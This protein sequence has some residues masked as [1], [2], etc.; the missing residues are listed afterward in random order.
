MQ[1]RI[2]ADLKQA[3]KA[4]D[5][6]T[7]SVLRMLLSALKYASIE[8]K[9]DLK[10]EEFASLVQKSVR[11][12][13]ESIEAFRKGG[14]GDLVEREEAE[15]KVLE[16]YLPA[17]MAGVEL[18]QA[19]DRLL[20]ELGITEKKDLGRAMKEFMA[21]HRGKADGKAVNALIASRLR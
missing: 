2:Q 21:R 18:E 14:R 6:T 17:Q 19:V 12:R 10:E 15:L 11:S 1:E 5:K 8:E 20:S 7:V 3:M 16:R 13:K 9:R 4:G